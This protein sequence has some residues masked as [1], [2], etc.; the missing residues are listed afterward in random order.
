VARR[1]PHQLTAPVDEEQFVAVLDCAASDG[2]NRA[3]IQRRALV[4]Y[5]TMRGYLAHNDDDAEG[6]TST[7]PTLPEQAESVVG[8]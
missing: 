8:S 1:F 2:V 3:E 4:S 5:L 7:S 6:I